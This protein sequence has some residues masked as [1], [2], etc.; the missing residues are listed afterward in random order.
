[1]LA[2]LHVLAP[3]VL[4]AVAFD[5][6]LSAVDESTGRNEEKAPTR[7]SY[8]TVKSKPLW[9]RAMDQS[10]STIRASSEGLVWDDTL[11]RPVFKRC[12]VT[13]A[14]ALSDHSPTV[15][16]QAN[17][18]D[19]AEARTVKKIRR[20]YKSHYRNL[21]RAQEGGPEYP[22]A[23]SD[24]SEKSRRRFDYSSSDDKVDSTFDFDREMGSAFRVRNVPKTKRQ[25]CAKLQSARTYFSKLDKT[26]L[27]VR[28]E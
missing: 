20:V 22:S 18:S 13:A 1:M 27:T 12:K 3:P 16:S 7:K 25:V 11:A 21:V 15:Q 17:S 9:K 8:R 14:A 24:S 2:I 23:S 10:E 28:A 5:L 4:D 6:D 19:S 26:S